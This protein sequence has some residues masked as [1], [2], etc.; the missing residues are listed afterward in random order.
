MT[1]R[2]TLKG[3]VIAEIVAGNPGGRLKSVEYGS[4]GEIKR[5]E[6][7]DDPP[8]IEP[9]PDAPD[10]ANGEVGDYD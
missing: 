7:H 2:V 4:F 8:A 1:D 9:H 10:Y 3:Q 5:I 6:W